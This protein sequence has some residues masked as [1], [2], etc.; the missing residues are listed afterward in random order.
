MNNDKDNLSIVS[1]KFNR[2]EPRNRVNAEWIKAAAKKK[3]K[4]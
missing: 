3:G 2:T 1:Q 4:K